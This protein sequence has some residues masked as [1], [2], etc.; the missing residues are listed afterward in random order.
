MRCQPSA[1]R[2]HLWGVRA[3]DFGVGSDIQIVFKATIRQ[4]NLQFSSNE[5]QPLPQQFKLR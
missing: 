3:E 2:F 5:K 4:Y 1:N